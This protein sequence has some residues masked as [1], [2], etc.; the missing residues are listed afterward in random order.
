[1]IFFYWSFYFGKIFLSNLEK[2]KNSGIKYFFITLAGLSSPKGFF[3]NKNLEPCC[4]EI[5][6]IFL[7]KIFD[8]I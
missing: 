2:T 1:M 3:P 5:H 6:L 8:K 4:K 7:Y